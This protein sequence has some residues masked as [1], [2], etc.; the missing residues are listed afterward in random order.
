MKQLSKLRVFQY[1]DVVLISCG[2]YSHT[3]VHWATVFDLKVFKL[4][5]KHNNMPALVAIHR[6]IDTNFK[7]HRSQRNPKK[8]GRV[9]EA[10]PVS[11]QGNATS[12]PPRTCTH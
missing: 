2:T 12:L 4:P 1:S 11:V 8:W 10:N 7:Q 3:T 6:V 9:R 5:S